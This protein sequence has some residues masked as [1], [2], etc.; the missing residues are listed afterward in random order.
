MKL[1]FTGGG[2]WDGYI[3]EGELPPQHIPIRI[4]VEP[5]RV[6]PTGCSPDLG[7]HALPEAVDL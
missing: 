1:H 7:S 6:P 4:P 2:L 5:R 3:I